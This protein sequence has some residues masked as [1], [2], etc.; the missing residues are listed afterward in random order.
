MS[1]GVKHGLLILLCVV[2]ACDGPATDHGIDL[3]RDTEE[4]VGCYFNSATSS[5]IKIERDVVL[6]NGEQVYD[7]YEYGLTGRRNLPTI[8]AWP[9]NVFRVSYADTPSLSFELYG[10]G[11][12][13]V[14]FSFSKASPPVSLEIVTFPDAAIL[15]FER[16]DC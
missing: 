3:P 4:I 11:D 9:G 5:T 14:N 1:L 15:D 12:G 6:L 2:P 8:L 10:N 16:T 7:R 13:P